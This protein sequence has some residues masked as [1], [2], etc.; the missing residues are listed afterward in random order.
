MT[1]TAQEIV[2][3][4]Q[5][6]DSK[7]VRVCIIDGVKH[8]SILNVIQAVTNSPNAKITWMRLK[9]TDPD[10]AHTYKNFKFPGPGVETPVADANTMMRI[11]FKLPGNKAAKFR[12]GSAEAFLH[13]LNPTPEFIQDMELRMAMLQESVDDSFFTPITDKT[14][15]SY[16][17]TNMYVRVRLPHEH[18][19]VVTHPKE[20]TMDRIKF[21]VAYDKQGRH[22]GYSKDNGYFAFAFMCRSRQEAE[23]AENYIKSTFGMLAVLN[24]REYLDARRL[25][26]ELGVEYDGESYEQYLVVARTL[27]VKMVEFIKLVY[28]GAYDNVYGTLYSAVETMQDLA[29]VEA[30]TKL[31]FKADTITREL[32]I[33][34]G[35]RN[36]NT[37]WKAVGD[38]VPK[39][40]LPKS[41]GPVISCH[42]VT[43]DEQQWSSVEL[44]ARTLHVEPKNVRSSV[45]S[46]RQCGGYVWRTPGSKKWVV[47]DGFIIDP[48]KHD[49]VLA[50]VKGVDSTGQ[51]VFENKAI[52]A[53]LLNLSYTIIDNAVGTDKL[54]GGKVWSFLTESESTTFVDEVDTS[55]PRATFMNGPDNGANGRAHGKIVAR[56]IS[57]GEETTYDSKNDAASMLGLRGEQIGERLDKPMHALGLVFRRFD[58]TM[59]WDPPYS[60]KFRTTDEKGKPIKFENRSSPDSYVV[61]LDDAGN[62]T[63]L[64]ENKVAAAQLTGISRSSIN[65]LTD[66]PQTVKGTK[67]RSA[68][69]EDYMT[70]VPCDPPTQHVYS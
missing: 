45:D 64:Y 30:P 11:I 2:S 18:T 52:A 59:R 57:S 42:L 41:K 50:Y 39:T 14:P 17:E 23:L 12:E 58:S 49:G 24:S 65:N 37:T 66:T 20:L 31:N 35:F 56:D 25:A 16:G 27:F 36:P 47:P 10:L 3:L 44:G 48:T 4:G 33:Q 22:S 32:A 43:G 40:G 38:T 46:P 15:R 63:G 26:G 5:D 51:V 53:R 21:G 1:L 67:W 29:I 9:E 19:V 8:A 70:F 7:D 68:V 62:V 34:F 69:P 55:S 13:F 6:F 60:F 61:S 28:P 54:V